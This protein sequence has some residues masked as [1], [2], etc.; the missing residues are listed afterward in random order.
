MI[1]TDCAKVKRTAGLSELVGR[2]KQEVIAG[3]TTLV[4]KRGDL[5]YAGRESKAPSVAAKDTSRGEHGLPV[6]P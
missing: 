2:I 5:Q 4:G 1:D 6:K 3:R